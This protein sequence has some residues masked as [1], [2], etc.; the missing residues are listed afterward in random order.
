MKLSTPFYKLKR[1]HSQTSQ[2]I[3]NDEIRTDPSV[4]TDGERERLSA[5][6]AFSP[7]TLRSL[8]SPI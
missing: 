3:N 2:I 5:L 8:L 1:L 4:T 6:S 7:L